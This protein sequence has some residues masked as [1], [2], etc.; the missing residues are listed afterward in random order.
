[1]NI[2]IADDVLI[3]VTVGNLAC[4]SLNPVFVLFHLTRPTSF[5]FDCFDSNPDKKM[6]VFHVHW[7][8]D[9][10]KKT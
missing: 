5:L 4:V 6:S 9:P 1:M 7:P 10:Q 2:N 8:M 3:L